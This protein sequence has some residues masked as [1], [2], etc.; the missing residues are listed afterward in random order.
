VRISIIVPTQRRPQ[1]LSTA[2]R[3]A[4]RQTGV[5]LG[6]LELV[7]ADNDAVDSARAAVEAFAAAAPFPV[8]YVHEPAPG[9]ANVR[10]A[11]MAV[12][13]GELIAFLDDDEEAPPDWLANLL[14]AQAAFEA[15]VVFGPVLGRAPPEVT[16]HRAYLE[17]FF[18]RHGP[19]QSGVI[20][21]YYGCGNSL[22]RR[23]ALPDP[24]RPFDPERNH[25]G[26]EDDRLFAQMKATGARFAWAADAPVWEDPAANRLGLDYALSRAF[27]YGQGG[28]VK[29]VSP[30]HRDWAGLAL[31]MMTGAG[32]AA[33]Y[34]AGAALKWATR[35]P[36]RA[37]MLDKA[38]RGLGKVFWWKAFHRN[39]YGL[40][41]PA[42]P[43]PSPPP[44]AASLPAQK[45]PGPAG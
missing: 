18:S 4:L 38:V 1:A 36:D 26:G 17:H 28:S 8:R 23:V 14:R 32:Q 7:V 31:S 40:A 35:A 37:F 3:S 19:A 22:L 27:A 42:A 6:R 33:V 21:T 30:P 9:V 25:I 15:D 13:D 43:R 12:S 5:D 2:V 45:A 20:D 39:F 10:N 24:R 44:Q 11:A 34:G 41:S 29:R 16:A